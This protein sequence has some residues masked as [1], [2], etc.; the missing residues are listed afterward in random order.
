MSDPERRCRT[1]LAVTLWL[2]SAVL[3][4]VL[5]GGVIHWIA[6]CP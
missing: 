5:A 4:G 6:Q 1:P 3:L 2:A